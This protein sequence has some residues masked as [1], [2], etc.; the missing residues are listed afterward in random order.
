MQ[1]K[2]KLSF[3]ALMISVFFVKSA[4]AEEENTAT[5]ERSPTQECVSEKREEKDNN[6]IDENLTVKSYQVQS[7]KSGKLVN[8][9]FIQKYG[10]QSVDGGETKD[11]KVCGGEQ[12]VFGE[13]SYAYNSKIYGEGNISGKQNIYDEGSALFTD[14]MSGGEQNIYYVRFGSEGGLAIDTKVY[15]AGIQ[16]VFAG[17]KANTVTLNDGALQ[18]VYAG[19]YVETLT[20]KGGATSLV[21]GG[22]V[23]EGTTKVN[24]S[25]RLFLYAGNDQDRTKAEDIILNGQEAKLYSV[26]TNT[27]GS[28]TSIQKLSGDGSVIFTATS[29]AANSPMRNPYYSLLKISD[30]SGKINFNFRANFKEQYGDYL[31]VENGSGHH[32]ISV[33]DSGTEITNSSLYIVDLI[34]VKSGNAHFI[35]KNYSLDGGA[36]MYQLKQKDNKNEKIWYLTAAEKGSSSETVPKTQKPTLSDF[37]GEEESMTI[38]HDPIISSYEDNFSF[39]ADDFGDGGS[40]FVLQNVFIN[41]NRTIYFSDDMEGYPKF[42]MNTIVEGGGIL[43]IDTGAFSKNTIIMNG[44]TEI[45]GEQGI[46]EFA[47]VYENGKQSVEGGGT[48]LQATIYGGEQTVFG[49]GYVNGGLV[50]S[51]AYN[52]KVYSQG[53]TLGQQNVYDDGMAV[54][55]KVMDGGIQNLGKWFADDSNF[56]EKSGGFAFNTEIFMGGVQHVFAGGEADGVT[57]YSGAFQRVHAG[58]FV[59]N[60]TIG[61]E[62]NSWVLAGASLGGEIKVHNLGQLY[63]D[64]GDD[65]QKTTVENIHLVGEESQ[66][67]VLASHD[68]DKSTHIQ[69]LSG[70]GRVIFTSLG[71]RLYYSKLYIDNLSGSMH[72]DL[73]VSIAEGKGDIL[74]LQNGSGNH[75]ISI[76]DSGFQIVDLSSTDFDLIVDQGGGASFT[77]RSF[78]GAKIQV[79]DGGTYAYGLKQKNGE[80]GSEKIWYLTPVE[81]S[82]VTTRNRFRRH[83]RSQNQQVSVSSTALFQG[84][85]AIELSRPDNSHPSFEE[86]QQPVVSIGAQSLKD[87]ML[88]RPSGQDELSAQSQK[89]I[90]VSDLLTTPSTDAV[91]SMSVAPGLIFH[92][93]LQA[94]RS[95]R[96]VLDKSK[97][98]AAFWTYGIK[99][100][101]TISADHLDFKL[102]QTGVVLGLSGLS[103]WEDGEFY[104]G[105]FGSYD[106]ARLTHARGGVSGLNT[107]GVGAYAT[108]VD[109]SGWYLD[110]ILKYNY[111]QNHLK[112]VSTNGSAIAGDYHQRAVGTSFEAGYRIKT[113]QCSWLQ[114]YGQFTWLQVEKKAIEL[115]NEMTGDINAFTSLRSEVGLSLGYEF[116]SNNSSLAYITAA[117]LRENKENNQT[118]I[119]EQHEFITDISGNAGKLGFGLSSF[120]SEKLKLYAQ[121]HYVKGRKTKQSFQGV[122]GVR[123]SF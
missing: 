4:G 47:I 26:A 40:K 10:L 60:L 53:E 57:L 36:Y 58:G 122:L 117:W 75:T 76:A 79:F 109:H 119:N 115:S 64:A 32:T 23:L 93:E 90:S 9:A 111:Y 45:I 87:K 49:E 16:R 68:D 43:S 55:T 44:G 107:Y 104:I 121:A 80:N 74:F 77:L 120:V 18:E 73:N 97:K 8:D 65:N 21:H 3:L 19:G 118:T 37:S 33:E 62:A 42:S 103:E 35:F 25:G 46:S 66:L 91:L 7:V 50:G 67:Y 38:L 98:N 108:Y 61:R 82:R 85:Q 84:K 54:G 48:A 15:S 11:T 88:M 105:G 14:V 96:G 22:V 89:E 41:D 100:K 116:G 20:I 5:G 24:N 123:Y 83:L 101:E 114:P 70:V 92:N 113:T 110:G 69:S 86:Q 63:L 59:K 1:R 99:S 13:G 106:H 78:S 31:I 95:G 12:T 28:S 29:T 94:V 72:F 27:N 81:I 39:Y 2:L 30:L 6:L 56:A 112:A 52:T 102:E 34:T 17:G 71:S 51:S